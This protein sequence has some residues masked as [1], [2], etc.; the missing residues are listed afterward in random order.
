MRPAPVAPGPR[1]C[2]DGV[3]FVVR[4]RC[5]ERIQL[6]L[7]DEQGARETA[8]LDFAERFGE[9]WR[10]FV[11]GVGSGA[12]YGLR[13]DGP[14]DPRAGHWF[15]PAKLLLDPYATRLDRPFV[16]SP[17]LRA[18]GVETAA[19]V[20]K[21]IVEALPW[22]S[23][24]APRAPDFIYELS[25]RAQTRLDA[26]VA[27]AARGTL[28]GLAAPHVI[29]RLVRLGVSHVELMPVAAW[30]DERHLPP[31]GLSNA[32]GYNPVAMMAPDPRLA[33]GGLADLRHAVAALR[34]AGIGVILDVVFNHTGESD[35][36]GPILSLR[37]L[38]N[39]LYYRRDAAG[40]FV[41]DAGC[42]NVLA[43]DEPAVAQL[44]LD[45]LR[46]YVRHA[47]VDGF[48]FDLATVLGRDARGFSP[49]APLLAAIAQ[50]PELRDRVLIAE[51]WDVGPGGYQIGRFRHPWREW[52][53]RYRDDVR[54]FWRGDAGALGAFATRLAGSAD[55]FQ[56]AARRPS[57]SVNFIAAHDGF[58][59]RDLVTCS[60]KRNHA[61]GEDNRDGSD[62]EICWIA[63]DPARDVRALLATLMLSR[64]TP[65]LTAGDEFGRTQ[66]GNNNAYA[67]DNATTWLDWERADAGLADF[68]AGLARLRAGAGVL[69]EDRFLTGRAGRGGAPD[70][71]WTLPDG[72]PFTQDDWSAGDCCALTLAPA[73]TPGGR[74]HLVFNRG[75]E[76]ALTPPAPGPGLRWR[77]ALDSA[78][79]FVAPRGGPDAPAKAPARAVLVLIESD[80]PTRAG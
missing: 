47:G 46:H 62:H 30:I 20:P 49:D 11:P 36:G 28:A 65:M 26:A 19:L 67:Q 31:L 56:A 23:R 63:Q 44:V 16:H 60:G 38:D 77:L 78:A 1:V 25:V 51:P 14:R 2:D 5:A 70:A 64:G 40:D 52:S 37:G 6:C 80:A 58:A 55:L 68:V 71:L 3:E 17:E 18:A 59:L 22:V 27:P 41:N 8:R 73:E 74:V 76:C 7:F 54:R 24:P 10:V 72:R 29:E 9:F 12:R 15:D 35:A 43:C 42:G 39:A 61:N 32:W 13:A 21:A 48:R 4:S 34:D 66:G 45:T 69:T 75:A 50:D 79:G 53:D 33:P 57:A